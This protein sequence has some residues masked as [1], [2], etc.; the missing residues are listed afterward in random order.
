MKL[1]LVAALSAL[2]CAGLIGSRTAVTL[3]GIQD[4]HSPFAVSV[5]FALHSLPPL[6]GG[7]AMGRLVD[8]AGVR[9][10]LLACGVLMAGALLLA[11]GVPAYWSYAVCGLV[12][13][14]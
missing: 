5:L 11:V 9:R 14:G 4:G 12:V 3:L 8:R 2:G 13:G 1:P 10:P 7:I 6:F